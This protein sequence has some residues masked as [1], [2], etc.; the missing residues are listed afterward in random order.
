MSELLAFTSTR[1]WVEEKDHTWWCSLLWQTNS[2]TS[3]ATYN[4]N[5]CLAHITEKVDGG[6]FL[7]M[8]T[9][10]P[11]LFYFVTLPS[12]RASDSHTFSPHIGKKKVENMTHTHFL[13][14]PGG[15]TFSP[16]SKG[17]R[18]VCDPWP[19]SHYS[20]TILQHGNGHWT[21][22]ATDGNLRVSQSNIQFP[23]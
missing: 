8:V 16:R 13:K 12:L 3:A 9:L 11:E 10:R 19:G 6:L 7:Y 14:V 22:S 20:V 21:V 15:T 5:V 2:Q 17:L 18:N 23:P 1:E 4:K